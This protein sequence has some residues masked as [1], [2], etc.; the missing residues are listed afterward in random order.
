M[1]GGIENGLADSR[2]AARLF[3]LVEIICQLNSIPRT[4]NADGLQSLNGGEAGALLNIP[5]EDRKKYSKI[6]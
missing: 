1:S 2:G 6:I 3:L 5:R 4:Q